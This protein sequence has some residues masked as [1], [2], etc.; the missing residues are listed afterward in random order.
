MIATWT[1]GARGPLIVT[2]ASIAVLGTALVSQYWGG[3]YPCVLCLFQRMPYR[4]AIGAGAV[5][6]VAVL[7]GWRGIAALLVAS[8]S[9]AFLTGAGIAAY[10][11]GVEQHWWLGSQACTG[12]A[13]GAATTVEEMRRLLE[14]AP[15]VRCDEIPWSMFGISMAGYNVFTSLG[16]AAF[17]A[18]SARA[19]TRRMR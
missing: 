3:L 18:L 8:C 10:H 19:L 5:A 7:L 12:V 4:F 11:V 6:T 15:V 2:L 1:S 13:A 16:L 17:A 9:L 14:T